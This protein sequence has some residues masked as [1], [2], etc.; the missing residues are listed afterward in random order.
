MLKPADILLLDEPTKDLDIP[1]LEVLE[2]SLEEFPGAIVLITHDR[3]LIDRLSDRLLH[4]DGR[5]HAQFFADYDQWL[6]AHQ[7]RAS[8]PTVSAASAKPA[9]KPTAGLSREERKE[10]DG[11][12][13]K[14]EKSETEVQRLQQQLHDPAIMSDAE[15]LKELY[16]ELQAAETKVAKLYER[17]QELEA[18]DKRG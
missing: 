17:W 2:D 8:V 9:K 13:K 3:Y 16:S 10:L 1:T 14:I 18:L 15:R 4:L 12:E 5:G 7:T 6:Q 11:I